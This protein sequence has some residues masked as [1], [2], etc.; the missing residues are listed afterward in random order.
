MED[1][2]LRVPM[3]PVSTPRAGYPGFDP[4]REILPAGYQLQPCRMPLPCA[5]LLEQDVAIPVRDGVTLYA[6]IY[7]PVDET[8]PV[9][10]ILAWGSWGK[11][12]KNLALPEVTRMANYIPDTDHPTQRTEMFRR[13]ETSG[14]NA[15]G[16]EDPAAW[17]PHG[18]AVVNV[19]P[20]GVYASGGEMMHF[21]GTQNGRDAYDVIEYLA[22]LPWCNGRIGTS[23][24][25]WYGIEQWFI[26]Q[27][28]PPHLAAIHPC[29]A[30]GDFYRDEMVRGGIPRLDWGSRTISFGGGDVED[31][32]AMSLTHPMMDEYW[33]DKQV[34][35]EKIDVPVFLTCSFTQW[36]HS[37]GPFEAFERLGTEKKWMRVHNGMEFIDYR[38]PENIAEVRR[39]FDRYLKGIENGWEE[40]PRVRLSVLDPGGADVI[41]RPETHFPPE[42]VQARRLYLTA[43][44]RLSPDAPELGSVSYCADDGAGTARFVYRFDRDTEITGF[45]R[46]H[47]FMSTDRALDMDVF[48]RVS[49]LDADGNRLRARYTNFY[50]GPNGRLRVSLRAT[51]DARS[52]EFVR[53]HTYRERAY[54]KP[55]EVAEF[56]IN[57]WPTAMRFHAGEQL[58]L[59]LAGFELMT[60]HAGDALIE[61]CNRGTHTVFTGGDRASYLVLPVMPEELQNQPNYGGDPDA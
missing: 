7:R 35:F 56:D 53:Y 44:G 43:D 58:E 61:T 45:S 27:E 23:G 21:F 28:R 50:S 49:K 47:L 41:G 33:E 2:I 31:I 19:D 38:L 5:M 18:Y 34:A 8:Q 32:V 12:G 11:R 20:R 37:R 25:H 24:N 36:N 55:F 22:G 51:D 42:R 46:A 6:D 3:Q 59:E 40:T 39:F 14:L 29:E 16:G 10:V 30:H 9:P 13:D 52:N 4:H 54:L 57:I 60:A 17:I 15:W 26:A 48:V 1:N